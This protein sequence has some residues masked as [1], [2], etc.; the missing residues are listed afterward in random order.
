MTAT[1]VAPIVARSSEYARRKREMPSGSAAGDRDDEVGGAQGG[2]GRGIASRT[3]EIAHDLLVALERSG[4]VDDGVVRP[5]AAC[6]QR[7]RDAGLAE[8][9]PARRTVETREHV[10]AGACRAAR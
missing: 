5:L 3:V 6:R 8:L 4:D 7:G 10:D 2:Q 1:G 9:G